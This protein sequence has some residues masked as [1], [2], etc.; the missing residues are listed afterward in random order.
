MRR[1]ILANNL[2]SA[3]NTQQVNR[4]NAVVLSAIIFSEVLIASFLLSRHSLTY[5]I[6]L[7]LVACLLTAPLLL[8]NSY[9]RQRQILGSR[10]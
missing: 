8:W 7:S 3:M 6:A 9:L 10:S 1:G 2:E 4:V 5:H